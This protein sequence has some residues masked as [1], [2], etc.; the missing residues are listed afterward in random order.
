ML[1]KI[2]ANSLGYLITSSSANGMVVK[3]ST[4]PSL[5]S[6]LGLKYPP[7]PCPRPRRTPRS[8][9]KERGCIRRLCIR[10]SF[11]SSSNGYRRTGT[12]VGVSNWLQ[13]DSKWAWGTYAEPK[14]HLAIAILEPL[15][16][17]RTVIPATATSPLPRLACPRSRT[18]RA[19]T[20]GRRT[21]RRVD[22]IGVDMLPVNDIRLG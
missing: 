15:C 13:R 20:L 4:H 9:H 10:R 11:P 2:T 6:R 7:H 3:S 22:G 8:C 12:W 16:L 17:R 19:F 18:R 1:S 5:C 14:P 21:S